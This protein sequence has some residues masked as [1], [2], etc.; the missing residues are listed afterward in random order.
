[1]VNRRRFLL[2]GLPLAA[3]RLRAEPE[4]IVDIHCHPGIPAYHSNQWVV[5]HQ[6]AHGI[7]TSALLPIPSAAGIQSSLFPK[8]TLG[9]G[10]A[11]ELAGRYPGEFL[12]FTV[13]DARSKGA[14]AYLERYLRA[15]ARGIGEVK[16]PLAC[17]SPKMELIYDIARDHG[18]PVLIHFQHGMFATGFERFPRVAEKYPTVTFIGHAQTWWGNIDR[19]HIQEELYPKGPLTPGGLTDR[20]LSDYPNVYGDLS[21][22]SGLDALARDRHHAVEFLARHQDKLCFGTDCEHPGTDDPSKC[23]CRLTS[24]LIRMLAEPPAAAKILHLNAERLLKL[25]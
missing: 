3:S 17:D 18:V 13:A 23:W 25:D 15:G 16:L 11:I 8:F 4:P 12:F 6:R 10:S 14:S 2:G 21:A 7:R 9:Q 20:L 22:S 1:V 24:Q 19:N 5:A